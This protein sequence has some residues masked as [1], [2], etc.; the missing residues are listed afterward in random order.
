MCEVSQIQKIVALKG[1][2]RQIHY[3]NDYLSLQ[4]IINMHRKKIALSIALASLVTSLPIHAATQ[5]IR[6]SAGLWLI[7]SQT[8]LFGHV[9]PDV[10]AMIRM[11]PVPLQDHVNKMLQQN[12]VRMQEDGT[13]TVCVSAQQIASKRF[14][15]DE[16]SGCIVGQGRHT[17]NIIR[18][19]IT[20]SAP[21]GQGYTVVNILSKTRWRA[22]THLELTVRGV[23]QD[24]DNQSQGSWLGSKCPAGM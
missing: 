20:C 14:V 18:Y 4:R 13:A 10:G 2:N 24:V 11:G 3:S 8:A 9:V 16:G 12:H 19:N 1:H 7:E 23:T 6:P 17:G 15:N 5:S 21:K 22:T